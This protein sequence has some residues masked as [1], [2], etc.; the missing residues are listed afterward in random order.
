MDYFLELYDYI[1]INKNNAFVNNYIKR[2]EIESV[3]QDMHSKTIIKSSPDIEEY[4]EYMDEE[5]ENYNDYLNIIKNIE[6]RI[7]TN[8]TTPIISSNNSNHTSYDFNVKT[9]ELELIMQ[10]SNT[11]VKKTVPA[12]NKYL[13]FKDYGSLED[14]F[15]IRA[16]D[17]SKGDYVIILDNEKISFIDLFIEIFKLEENIDKNLA[18]YW[19]DKISIFVEDNNLSYDEF[20]E[21]YK[22]EG[23][24]MGIQTIRN[25]IK[26]KNISP[27]DYKTE[28]TYLA[29]VMDDDFL[30]DNIDIMG[31]EFRK[32]KSMHIAMGRNLKAIMKGI[33]VDDF[34]LNYDLLSLEEQTMHT[35]IKNSV[36]QVIKVKSNSIM[37]FNMKINLDEINKDIIEKIDSLDVGDNIKN[38]LKEALYEEYTHRD[39]NYTL[40]DK[41]SSNYEPL[42]DKYYKGD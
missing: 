25:W 32:I 38:F 17:L 23:G 36:Y 7:S 6:K 8:Q 30:L 3:Q 35:I 18:Q 31:E 28:L 13:H 41:R 29:K 33:I 9:I 2:F 21:M 15:E 5:T 20:H 22:K 1:G 16:E 40:S 39:E 4:G 26:G 42:I 37:G 19:K 14:A 27:R 10:N 24:T 11:H 12:K 34:S